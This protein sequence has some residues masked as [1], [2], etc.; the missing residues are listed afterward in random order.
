L[1]Y[2]ALAMFQETPQARPP[3]CGAIEQPEPCE[4]VEG[5]EHELVLFLRQH[6]H[7]FGAHQMRLRHMGAQDLTLP[8]LDSQIFV[9]IR[10]RQPFEQPLVAARG[11]G[12]GVRGDIDLARLISLPQGGEVL[13]LPEEIG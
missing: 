1:R 2:I 3:Y 12:E 7:V 10:Q 8:R 11:I 6:F 13:G 5:F 4:S 9:P